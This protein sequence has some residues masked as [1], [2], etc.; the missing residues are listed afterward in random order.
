MRSLWIELK[1]KKLA[2]KGIAPIDPL[3]YMPKLKKFYNDQKL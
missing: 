1:N 2:E 3:D